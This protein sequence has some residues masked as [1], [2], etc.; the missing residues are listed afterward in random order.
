[1]NT[2]TSPLSALDL[3]SIPLSAVPDLGA[4]LDVLCRTTGRGIPDLEATLVGL[5]EDLDRHLH[6]DPLGGHTG[7]VGAAAPLRDGLDRHALL[8]LCRDLTVPLAGPPSL[9]QRLDGPEPKRAATAIEQLLLRHT[10]LGAGSVHAARVAAL[11]AG[12]TPSELADTAPAALRTR[13]SSFS[14]DVAG[15]AHLHA[16]QLQLPDWAAGP[17]AQLLTGRTSR[18]WLL[19]NS[20]SDNP[21]NRISC[22]LMG[23]RK[24]I[25]STGLPT[26]ATLSADSIRRTG[27]RNLALHG[28][29]DGW[30]TALQ[31][32]GYRNTDTADQYLALHH[33][34]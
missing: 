5:V 6:D 34:L 19:H 1:M 2:P 16:R 21:Q 25:D 24:L 20:R 29:V 4:M 23:L 11:E 28:G 8:V 12:G 30:D 32:A 26:A 17:H 18:R 9:P 22:L 33:D 3:R 10:A 14:L 27:L 15:T 31:E 13:H 7:F